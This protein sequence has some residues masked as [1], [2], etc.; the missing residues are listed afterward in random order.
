MTTLQPRAERVT[1]RV[2]YVDTDAPRGTALMSWWPT[3]ESPDTRQVEI[4][5]E[6]AR[7]SSTTRVGM[8][9]FQAG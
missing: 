6:G 7:V 5:L 3:L 1:V 4:A 9:G 2:T 8:F